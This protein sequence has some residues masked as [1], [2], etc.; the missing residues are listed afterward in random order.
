MIQWLWD[1][2]E[3]DFKRDERAAFLKFVTSCSCPPLL[4]FAHL[5]VEGRKDDKENVLKNV[6][7]IL[8]Y[9]FILE[10]SFLFYE[11]SVFDQMC[12]SRGR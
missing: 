5:Q 7:L 8:C 9:D 2:L 12:R 3:S 4:G 6:Y 1:I 11:A 10:N